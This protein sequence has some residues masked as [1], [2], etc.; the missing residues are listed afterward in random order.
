MLG[1]LF[2]RDPNR[3]AADRLYQHIANAAREPLLYANHGIP[4]TV[5]GRFESL[6]LHTI[7]VL[8][9]LDLLGPEGK[10]L[11]QVL[12]DR[13]FADIDSAMRQIGI[14]DTSVGK[15]VKAFAKGFYGRA[16]AY[17]QALAVD[18]DPAAL[19]DAVERNL[20]GIT[21]GAMAVS[22]THGQ[23]LS[24]YIRESVAML[25]GCSFQDLASPGPMFAKQCL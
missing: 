4:D 19:P 7:L 14:G 2:K 16:S 5:E 17:Q 11:A 12:I 21:T 1:K 22:E 3:E 25:D 18:A 6:A 9:R 24:R 13:F 8:R 15:K 23:S 20:L 10:T